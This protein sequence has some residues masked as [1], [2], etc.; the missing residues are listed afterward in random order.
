LP[1]GEAM[2]LPYLHCGFGEKPDGILV[3]LARIWKIVSFGGGGGES[4]ESQTAAR[5]HRRKW[6]YG[7][8]N[9]FGGEGQPKWVLVGWLVAEDCSLRWALAEYR[10]WHTDEKDAKGW[11]RSVHFEGFDEGFPLLVEA[12][13]VALERLL[14][15]AEFFEFGFDIAEFFEEALEEVAGG[16][17]DGIAEGIF[18]AGV[19][20]ALEIAAEAVLLGHQF[21]DLPLGGEA[22]RVGFGGGGSAAKSLLEGFF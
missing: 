22:F 8:G 18:G 9:R 19:G 1:K 2:V 16:F 21:G 6:M 14:I 12:D 15:F 17:L 10:Q 13:F 5:R 4:E 11:R 20:K 7:D 3:T